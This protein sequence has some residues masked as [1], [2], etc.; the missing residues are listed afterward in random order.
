MQRQISPK[1]IRLPWVSVF[2]VLHFTA[3]SHCVLSVLHPHHKLNYFKN[4]KWEDDWIETARQLVRDEFDLSYNLPSTSQESG[5]STTQVCITHLCA[6]SCLTIFF[7]ACRLLP[8]H[9]KVITF[10]TTWLRLLP[11]SPWTFVTSL[12]TTSALT[13]SMLSM[14]FIGGAIAGQNI[15]TCQEWPLIILSSLICH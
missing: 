7:F 5:L 1:P 11:P 13:L 6:L 9:Q 14:Q 15:L 3:S 10:S 12:I 2:F 4:V 8:T